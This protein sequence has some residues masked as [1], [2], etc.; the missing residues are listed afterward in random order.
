MT[1]A[2]D[3]LIAIDNAVK[4]LSPRIY[5]LTDQHCPKTGENGEQIFYGIAPNI[6]NEN[7]IILT[8][9]DNLS[10]FL[11]ICAKKGWTPVD[12]REVW[13]DEQAAFD[14]IM[15]DNAQRYSQMQ[16]DQD[17]ERSDHVETT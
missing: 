2:R 16:Q 14:R 17:V 6:V 11:S 10:D 5:Y 1:N 15:K 9:P 8:H 7:E 3:I 13:K 4:L 12:Q